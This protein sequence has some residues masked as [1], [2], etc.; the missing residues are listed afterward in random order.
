MDRWYLQS[1]TGH[2]ISKSLNGD[3]V[4]YES[5]PNKLASDTKMLE[6]FEVLEKAKQRCEKHHN[7]ESRKE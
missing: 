2:R 5:W 1:D 7:N 3:K 6:A 4:L